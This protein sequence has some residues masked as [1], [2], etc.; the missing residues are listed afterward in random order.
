MI[1]ERESDYL[2]TIIDLAKVYQW[3]V[4]HSRPA[5]TNKGWRTAIQGD[6]GCPDLILVRMPRVIFAEIKTKYG[7]L[8]DDQNNWILRLVGCPGVETYIWRPD[9][10]EE[11]TRIL[12]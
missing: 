4:H 9:D 11:I 12:R 10:W 5:W 3:I 1:R 8:S 6:P 7:K 2:S